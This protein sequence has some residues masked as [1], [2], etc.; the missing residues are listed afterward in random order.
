METNSKLNSEKESGLTRE[1]LIGLMS[2][3]T[4]RAKDILMQEGAV[5]PVAF[6]VVGNKLCGVPLE[7]CNDREKDIT[8]T[9]IKDIAKKSGAEAVITIMEAWTATAENGAFPDCSVSEMPNRR[10]CIVVTGVS[11][12]HK[13]MTMVE[14]SHKGERIILGDEKPFHQGFDSSFTDGIWD[15]PRKSAFN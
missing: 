4:G 9:M 14:F 13:F 10:E 3:M 8:K 15:S 11:A 12:Y 5:S 6:L 2:Q 7:F 1:S